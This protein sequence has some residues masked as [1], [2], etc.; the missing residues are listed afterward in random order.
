[1]NPLDWPSQI[2]FRVHHVRISETSTRAQGLAQPKVRV[3]LSCER[4]KQPCTTKGAAGVRIRQL[5]VRAPLK[6]CQTELTRALYRAWGVI[7]AL[8][9]AL[10]TAP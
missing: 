3:Q 2:E 4:T 5:S 6:H 7:G 10:N 9:G 8:G 1:M